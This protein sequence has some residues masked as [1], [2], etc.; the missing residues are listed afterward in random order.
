MEIAIIVLLV[1]N[2]LFTCV[3]IVVGLL[4]GSVVV[5]IMEVLRRLP[6]EMRGKRREGP[7][8]KPWYTYL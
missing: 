2:I 5:N 7:V 4:V 1:L 6:D 8:D 3:S